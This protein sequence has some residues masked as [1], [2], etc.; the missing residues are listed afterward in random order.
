MPSIPSFFSF[1]N[2]CSWSTVSKAAERSK[3]RTPTTFPLCSAFN[4]FAWAVANA[5]VVERP[6]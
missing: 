6:Y 4:H 3:P 5:V 1:G 2:N